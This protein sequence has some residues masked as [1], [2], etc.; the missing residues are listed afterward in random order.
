VKCGVDPH[1]Y[2][3][4]VLRVEVYCVPVLFADSYRQRFS[5]ANLNLESEADFVLK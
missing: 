1:L 3:P 4:V 5:A 2:Q